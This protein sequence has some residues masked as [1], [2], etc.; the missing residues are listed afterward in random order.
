V[1]YAL[2]VYGDGDTVAATTVCRGHVVDGPATL[3]NEQ[4]NEVHVVDAA[5]LD[6]AIEEAERLAGDVA[7]E[8]RPVA[9]ET[10]PRR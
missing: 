4:L 1:R 6:G 7:V 5:S 8:I 2:L 9:E 3:A 10:G